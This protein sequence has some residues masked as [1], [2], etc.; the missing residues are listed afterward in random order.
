MKKN[1]VMGSSTWIILALNTS[2]AKSNFLVSIDKLLLKLIRLLIFL[3]V[4]I[5]F[6]DKTLSYAMP[7]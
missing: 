1:E 4:E 2:L 3:N 7:Q 5:G 6:T